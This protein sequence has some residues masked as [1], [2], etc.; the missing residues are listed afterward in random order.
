MHNFLI[1]QSK[2]YP[3]TT[4]NYQLLNSF[5]G[6]ITCSSVHMQTVSCLNTTNTLLGSH[7]NVSRFTNN[8]IFIEFYYPFYFLLNGKINNRVLN[9][10]LANTATPK[11]PTIY[12]VTESNPAQIP[13]IIDEQ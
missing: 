7:D 3:C 4:K 1:N 2:T 8:G 5:K 6:A 12:S 13:C 10:V 11:N 9:E